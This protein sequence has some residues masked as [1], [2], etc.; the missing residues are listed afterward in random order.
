MRFS[1]LIILIFPFACRAQFDNELKGTT[2]LYG[3]EKNMKIRWEQGL[4]LR[5]I[6]SS[7][8]QGSEEHLPKPKINTIAFSGDTAFSIDATINENCC[9][10]FLGELEVI[11]DSILNLS[12]ITYG[13]QCACGCCFG[14]TY[15]IDIDRT[16]DYSPDKLTYVM[17]N[18]MRDT[19]KPINLRK[20]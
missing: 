3:S 15:Q 19:L 4:W 7:P 13:S 12:Y 9:N 17:L 8:C 11:E 14:I 10:S 18:G 20:R 6:K 5:A 2:V 1:L 16:E